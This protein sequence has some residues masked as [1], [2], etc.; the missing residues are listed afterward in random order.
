MEASEGKLELVR[1]V[2]FCMYQLKIGQPLSEPVENE[3]L[4][5]G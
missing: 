3:Q 2:P 4:Q 5:S 1:C